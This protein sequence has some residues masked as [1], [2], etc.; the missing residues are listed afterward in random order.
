VNLQLPHIERGGL[1][2]IR[3]SELV[4][5]DRGKLDDACERFDRHRIR[6]I[7]AAAGPARRSG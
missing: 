7:D 1:A 4:D 3:A 5:K 2:A 6:F